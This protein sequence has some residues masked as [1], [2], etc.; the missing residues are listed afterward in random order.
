MR[1]LL[2]ALVSIDA[3]SPTWNRKH[4]VSSF[5]YIPNPR[6]LLIRLKTA[7]KSSLMSSKS[8]KVPGISSSPSRN[9]WAITLTSN[10]A[11]PP[12]EMYVTD[13]FELK[14]AA[15]NATFLNQDT[16]HC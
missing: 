9:V 14:E 16:W 13:T 6:M 15:A 11:P 5:L 2:L 8:F 12:R 10:L 3:N 1:F 4:R 7:V